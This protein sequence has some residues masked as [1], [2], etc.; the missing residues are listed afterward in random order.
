MELTTYDSGL[1]LS[2]SAGFYILEMQAQGGPTIMM[3]RYNEAAQELPFVTSNG[4]F[5]VTDGAGNFVF[6]NTILPAFSL[7]TDSVVAIPAP[8]AA[9]LFAALFGALVILRR[10]MI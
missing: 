7:S 4:N 8:A 9:P 5:W 10:R 2:L 3:E 1:N 6:S